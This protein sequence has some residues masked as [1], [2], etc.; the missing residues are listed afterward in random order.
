MFQPSKRYQPEKIKQQASEII[1]SN[2]FPILL[3]DVPVVMLII[4]DAR[5]V[6]YVNR[7]LLAIASGKG[8][9]EMLGIR[10]G[11]CLDCIHALEGKYGCGS[12]AYCKVCGLANTVKLSEGG[13]EGLG[14]CT[15]SLQDGASLSLKVYTKPFKYGEEHFVFISIEDISDLKARLM[16]ESIFLHDLR[17]TSAILSGLQEV[18]ENLEVAETKRI[19]KEV[20]SRID[21]EIKSYRLITSAENKQLSARTSLLNLHELIQEVIESLML[22]Q[23]FRQKK[24][25]YAGTSLMLRTDKTLLR[26]VIIN[27]LKNAFEAGPVEDTVEIGIKK[28]IKNQRIGIFIKNRQVMPHD[29]KLQVFQKSFSTKGLGRGWGTYSIKLLTEKYLEGRASFVSE[30]KKGTTFIVELPFANGG[31]QN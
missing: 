7:D 5:Q 9:P 18:Y 30:E 21:E 8:K 1:Q 19:L 23:K 28:D 4:N 24:I 27:M 15:I 2:Y 25:K 29:V 14:E 31:Q 16:L 12:T 10:P 6:V 17:N 13:S 11:E 3:E 22:N 20:A 26:Q